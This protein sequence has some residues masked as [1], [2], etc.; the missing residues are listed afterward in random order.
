[1]GEGFD[2]D[3]L[4][5]LLLAGPVAF[6]GT[7]AQWVGRLHRVREGKADVVVMDYADL[8]IPMLDREWRK[9]VKAYGKLGYQMAG[10]GTLGSSAS[11]GGLSRSDTFSL[12]RR[13]RRPC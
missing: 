12:A 4:D 5:T 9:R 7:L 8:A 10:D 13:H 2:L 6:E 1:M 11:R 3:R